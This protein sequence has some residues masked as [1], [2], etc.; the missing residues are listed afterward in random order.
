[1]TITRSFFHTILP[2]EQ[3]LKICGMEQLENWICQWVKP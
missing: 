1:M 3:K 2:A